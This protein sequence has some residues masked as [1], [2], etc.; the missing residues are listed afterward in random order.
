MITFNIY[1]LGIAFRFFGGLLFGYIGDKYG[2]KTSLIISLF[3]TGISTALL[4]VLPDNSVWGIYAT[5]I[6]CLIRIIQ[7][8]SIGGE[9]PNA[10]IF[11]IEHLSNHKKGVWYHSC[12]CCFRYFFSFN[13]RLPSQK[14]FPNSSLSWR[15]P[16][17][18]GGFVAVV[19][20]Y[21]RLKVQET[22]IFLSL[23]KD[24][25]IEKLP[26]KNLLRYNYKNVILATSVSTV[27]CV[28]SYTITGYFNIFFQKIL[29]LS[30]HLAMSY[31]LFC[32]F[33]FIMSLII[34]GYICDK[35]T[36]KVLFKR[37]CYW[38]IILVLP[39]FYCISSKSI[40]LTLSSLALFS[41][42]AAS[43]CSCIY[44][45]I[46]NLYAPSER[47]TGISFSLNLGNSIVATVSIIISKYLNKISFNYAQALYIISVITLYLVI[48]SYINN[49]KMVRRK[50]HE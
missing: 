18:L 23:Q 31:S 8:L 48:S 44:S 32:S 11:I 36:Y 12:N 15:I 5:G 21:L 38:I 47:C 14:L 45:Y 39:V 6:F 26:I 3:A 4:G 30:S 49:K 2:R 27:T 13:Y 7:G 1:I 25:L 50:Q 46:F 9:V 42:M 33:F 17:I 35:I 16:F 10:A 34:M 37:A 41:I 28:M 19:G 24:K 40:Y 29:L 43:V 20:L 22:P